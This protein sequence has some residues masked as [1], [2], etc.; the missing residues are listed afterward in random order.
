MPRHD[1]AGPKHE[2]QGRAR[3]TEPGR[4]SRAA[5]ASCA[6]VPPVRDDPAFHDD[7]VLIGE[8]LS[9][10]RRRRGIS[11]QD[12]ADAIGL[13]V[14]DL[15]DIENDRRDA[16]E[17]ISGLAEALGCSGLFLLK[18]SYGDHNLFPLLCQVLSETDRM[19]KVNPP[20]HRVLDLCHEGENLR[21]FMGQPGTL[22]LPIYRQQPTS[23]G[24]AVQQGRTVAQGERRRLGV[25]SGP[26]HDIG[27]VIG[28]Q[29]I[30]VASI[31]LPEH[32]SGLLV[33][34]TSIGTVIFV[35]R[36]HDP[37][38]Q[39]FS[40]AHEYAHALFDRDNVVIATRAG[41]PD[42]VRERRANAFAAAFLMPPDGIAERLMD[43]GKGSLSRQTGA[44]FDVSSGVMV[45]AKARARPGSGKITHADVATLAR[46]F[47]VSY[48]AMA[49]RL[50]SLGHIS[51]GERRVFLAQEEVGKNYLRAAAHFSDRG[52][53]GE[54][55]D[56]GVREIHARIIQLAVEAFRRGE[57][58]GGRLR[59][60]GRM[61]AV[62]PWDLLCLG[63][64]VRQD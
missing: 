8:R 51:P 47:G 3:K 59:D 40:F 52:P 61:L 14:A 45:E 2:D 25:G 17:E 27:K 30:W 39:R 55:P 7:P 22:A 1:P 13:S 57:I 56:M 35:N 26:L 41:D 11:Q 60:V 34:H 23:V 49:W 12:M 29:G 6:P 32:L 18:Q 38:R 46:H 5:D 9:F 20:E 54:T 64:E 15:A 48:E 10:A 37:V 28:D 36:E 21:R 62:D 42:S 19:D 43:L 50:Q 31:E 4:T 24:M 58:S 33:D 53:D 63:R 16:G 44:I